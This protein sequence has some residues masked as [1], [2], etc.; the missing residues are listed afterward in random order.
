M[1]TN[2]QPTSTDH[3]I[4]VLRRLRDVARNNR[5]WDAMTTQEYYCTKQALA[6]ADAILAKHKGETQ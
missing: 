5:E 2:R 1:A 4:G 6:D 3:L